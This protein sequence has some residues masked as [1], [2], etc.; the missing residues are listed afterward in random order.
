MVTRDGGRRLPFQ[1][2]TSREWANLGLVALAAAYVVY[3]GAWVA[4]WGLFWEVGGDFASFWASAEIA[5]AHGFARV[6]DLALQA[7]FQQALLAAHVAKPE[8]AATSAP[9]PTPYLPPFIAPFVLLLCLGPA[10]GFAVW[11]GLSLLLLAGYLWRLAGCFALPDRRRL[12]IVT[13]LSLPAFSNLFFGQV[14]AFLV[15]F[16]G[17]F[18]VGMAKN[19]DLRAGLWLS[20]LLW[21]PQI[22]VVLLPGLLIARQ[23]R[24]LA[25]LAIGTAVILAASLYL[26]GVEGVLDLGRL[27]FSYTSGLPTNSPESMANWRALALNLGGFVPQEVAWGLAA[28]GLV[29]TVLVALRLWLPPYRPPAPG[30]QLLL[31]ATFTATSAITWH[32]HVHMALPTAV[33]LLA[34]YGQGLLPRSLVIVWLLLPAPVFLVA[35]FTATHPMAVG[36]SAVFLLD[37]FLLTWA[38]MRLLPRPSAAR[39]SA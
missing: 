14:S 7:Q 17:E 18:A 12:V 8:V 25:G 9:V 22:L 1:S 21:K 19:K 39:A 30:N 5:R 23:F 38:A 20:G 26:A 3:A 16:T 29:L 31:L 24:V 6:Y 13:M 10:A 27:V 35:C 33:F 11:T 15:L 34:A 2:L 36:G 37:M 28:V 32:S 4:R